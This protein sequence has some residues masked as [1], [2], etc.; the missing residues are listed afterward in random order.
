MNISMR[1]TVTLV[2]KDKD[3]NLKENRHVSE[4][5]E[6]ASSYTTESISETNIPKRKFQNNNKAGEKETAM[7]FLSK[8]N[9]IYGSDFVLSDKPLPE[10]NPVDCVAKDTK[11]G[12]SLSLQIRK[13][14][15][16][17]IKDLKQGKIVHRSGAR[18]AIHHAAIKRAIVSKSKRYPTEVKNDLILLLDGWQG[19]RQEDLDEFKHKEQEFL[20]KIGFCEVWF[21]GDEVID[22]LV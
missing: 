12:N 20:S 8:I 2:L 1:D 17:P 21:V 19:V 10:D 9:T 11:T 7:R 6:I 15:D 18:Y 16:E 5:L 4:D 22:R 3:G 14:D 13:S